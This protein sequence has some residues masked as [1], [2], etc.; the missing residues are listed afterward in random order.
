MTVD[1]L[2]NSLEDIREHKSGALE[3]Q[4]C[5]GYWDK[6]HHFAQPILRMWKENDGQQFLG[7]FKPD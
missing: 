3:V 7:V 4:V 2:I 1:D 6:K 5:I